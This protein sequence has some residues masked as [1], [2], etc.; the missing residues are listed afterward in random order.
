MVE[1]AAKTINYPID[2]EQVSKLIDDLCA[3]SKK[4][5]VPQE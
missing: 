2:L 3:L 1:A 5:N 4:V